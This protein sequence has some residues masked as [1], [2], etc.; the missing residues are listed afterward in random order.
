MNTL[1]PIQRRRNAE[2]DARDYYAQKVGRD[3]WRA[4]LQKDWT[5][6]RFITLAFNDD[7]HSPRPPI[8]Q[9]QV[10]WERAVYEWEREINRAMFGRNWHNLPDAL[11]Y[12][13]FFLELP[14]SHPHWH[15]LVQ[16]DRSPQYDSDAQIATFDVEAD[17][18]WKRLVRTGSSE[19]KVIVDAADSASRVKYVMK[20]LPAVLNYD[21]FRVPRQSRAF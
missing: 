9:D 8:R 16:F 10:F 3:L 11:P 19:N 13:F 2:H 5:F 15:G 4:K 14:N 12:I 7:A 20:D 18:V 1:T 17:R 21:Y 6:H